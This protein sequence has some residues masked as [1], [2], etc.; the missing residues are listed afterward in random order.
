MNQE[1]LGLLDNPGVQDY[2]ECGCSTAR[3]RFLV[4][5]PAFG[6]TFEVRYWLATQPEHGHNMDKVRIYRL[7]GETADGKEIWV[8]VS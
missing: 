4:G 1:K 2:A 7:A 5:H 3:F 6:N 8:K